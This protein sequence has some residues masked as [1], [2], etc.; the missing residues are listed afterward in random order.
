MPILR[1]PPLDQPPRPRAAIHRPLVPAAQF[2]NGY[3]PNSNRRFH[4]RPTICPQHIPQTIGP[5]S[6][7]KPT[8][9]RHAA[10]EQRSLVAICAKKRASDMGMQH[11]EKGPPK[12]EFVS[13]QAG[14]LLFACE[15]AVKRCE[16]YSEALK[17]AH[18][19]RVVHCEGVLANLRAGRTTR[20]GKSMGW[21]GSSTWG[22]HLH[23]TCRHRG[24][25]SSLLSMIPLMEPLS[26]AA[27]S[28]MT[29][30]SVGA[31]CTGNRPDHHKHLIA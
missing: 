30:L 19:P 2:S 3:Q 24:G 20:P 11:R 10:T 8:S 6:S 21:I 4:Q 16:A 23:M 26:A 14:T 25:H 17:G 12:P 29:A 5:A 28:I 27:Y 18:W 1:M 9:S 31:G 15:L 7:C 13:A 22:W